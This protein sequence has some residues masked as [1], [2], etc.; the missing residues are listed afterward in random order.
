MRQQGGRGSR[1]Q[2]PESSAGAAAV[3]GA[4]RG[5]GS[6]GPER[7]SRGG[8]AMDLFGDLRRMN[9]R[10]VPGPQPTPGAAHCKHQLAGSFPPLSPCAAEERN[11][12]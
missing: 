1:L 9:K 3:A 8:A 11:R 2:I 12:K 4:A 7:G 10:Q 5:A 6:A